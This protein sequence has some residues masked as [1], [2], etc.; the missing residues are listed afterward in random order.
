MNFFTRN[1]AQTAVVFSQHHVENLLSTLQSIHATL[2]PEHNNS[3]LH[4]ITSVLRSR[5]PHILPEPI[6]TNPIPESWLTLPLIHG[7]LGCP[8]PILEAFSYLQ[9][10][11]TSTSTTHASSSSIRDRDSELARDSF[12]ECLSADR[13]LYLDAKRRWEEDRTTYPSNTA[14][15]PR[16][17]AT[18]KPEFMSFEEYLRGR[19]TRSLHWSATYDHLMSPAEPAYP[20]TS[21]GTK[22][23][24]K[25]KRW[26]AQFPKMEGSPFVEKKEDYLSRK[27]YYD[28]ENPWD[29]WFALYA[30]QMERTFGK[31][32]MLDEVMGL[33]AMV[34]K[35]QQKAVKFDL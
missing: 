4:F 17:A 14:I 31:V 30:E 13:T 23:W 2:F 29:W 24:K 22:L 20:S 27:E 15:F 28:L 11:K 16:N 12:T 19:E 5:F 34:T 9:A 6:D 8:Q 7:G 25:I 35:I 21:R 33:G 10:F 3:F 32:C 18:N 26:L 1:C